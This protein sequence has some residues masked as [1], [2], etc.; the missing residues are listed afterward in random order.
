MKAIKKFISAVMIIA[1]LISLSGCSLKFSSFENLIRPPKLSGKYQ[2]LQDSFE[3]KV[4]NF[5]LVT[6]EN[7]LYQSAFVTFDID[8]D[9]EEEAFVF[10]KTDE[11]LDY[12]NMYYFKFTDNEWLPVSCVSGLGSSVDFVSFSD[13]N[14]DKKYELIIGWTL[15]SSKT[16]KIFSV[17]S[18]NGDSV[19]E[20]SRYPYSILKIFDVNGNGTDDIFTVSVASNVD[21]NVTASATAYSFDNKTGSLEIIG[22]TKTDGNVSSY[23]NIYVESINGKSIVYVDSL[24]G[25]NGMFTDVVCWDDEKNTLVAPLYD[26]TTQ[27]TKSTQRVS[28]IPCFDIDGDNQLE[29]PVSV[30][31]KGSSDTTKNKSVNAEITN[32]L[33]FT[34]WNKF[35]DN[36]LKP[37][38]YSLINEKYSYNINIKPSWAGRLTILGADGQWDFYRYDSNADSVVDLLFSIY[39]YKRGDTA[40]TEKYKDYKVLKSTNSLNYVYYISEAGTGFGITE[41]YIENNFRILNFG[42]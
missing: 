33:Y 37:V 16:N 29:I 14:S 31:M 30:E 5:S 12:V 2:G 23:E 19:S 20:V 27:S 18:Q 25:D 34:R 4:N 35:A 21:N 10:Y 6:P 26:S 11:T 32:L 41:E 36:S 15:L 9:G 28:K 39:V 7:G 1:M 8:S 24:M 22:E 17:Y 40:S 13:I 3:S 38:G 42:G